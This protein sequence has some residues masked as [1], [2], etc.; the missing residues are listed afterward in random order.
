M[1]EE[2]STGMLQFL[3]SIVEER[4]LDVATSRESR[5]KKRESHKQAKA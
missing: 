5:A 1:L 4:R 3:T 2:V